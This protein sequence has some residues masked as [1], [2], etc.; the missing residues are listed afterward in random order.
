MAPGAERRPASLRVSLLPGV[1]R[2]PSLGVPRCGRRGESPWIAS[3]AVSHPAVLSGGIRR[4]PPSAHKLT[5]ACTQ[6]LVDERASGA[7][8]CV[9]DER[10]RDARDRVS[11]VL[12]S[13][14]G[15]SLNRRVGAPVLSLAQR[16]RRTHVGTCGKPHGRRHPRSIQEVWKRNTKRSGVVQDAL[17]TLAFVSRYLR[18]VG[19][20]P[21]HLILAGNWA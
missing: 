7:Q 14:A 17:D 19:R 10:A 11:G 18:T 2:S 21:E 9:D 20:M 4:L 15:P 1:V 5:A 12:P 6:R 3:P 16:H 8:S 13:T